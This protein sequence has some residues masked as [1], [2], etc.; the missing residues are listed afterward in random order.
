MDAGN[1]AMKLETKFSLKLKKPH[2][3]LV[4]WQQSNS[5]APQM[6]QAG[7]VWNAESQPYLYLGQMNAYSKMSN[8]EMALSSATAVSA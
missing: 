7:A 3:Y 6:V 5:M 8:D 2:S 1:G 4:E